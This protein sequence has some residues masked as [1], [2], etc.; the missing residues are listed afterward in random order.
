MKDRT[1]PSGAMCDKG[2][3]KDGSSKLT[4]DSGGFRGLGYDLLMYLLIQCGQRS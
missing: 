1:Q 3:Q 2:V 4:V